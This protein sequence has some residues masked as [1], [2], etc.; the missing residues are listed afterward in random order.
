MEWLTKPNSTSMTVPDFLTT[1]YTL[2]NLIMNHRAKLLM[3][4]IKNLD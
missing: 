3:Q 2:L 4:H 1:F